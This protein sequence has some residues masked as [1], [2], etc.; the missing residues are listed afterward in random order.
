LRD[1]V[2]SLFLPL[3]VNGFVIIPAQVVNDSAW[4]APF[5]VW[6]GRG[7]AKHLGQGGIESASRFV[8]VKYAGPCFANLLRRL[9]LVGRWRRW[10]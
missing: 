5:L 8:Q 3:A 6:L 9:T 7:L 1:K 10:L 2:I 4:L